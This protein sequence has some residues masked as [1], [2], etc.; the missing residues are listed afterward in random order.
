MARPRGMPRV[1]APCEEGA[2]GEC[3]RTYEVC[4]CR[5]CATMSAV[6]VHTDFELPPPATSSEHEEFSV[7]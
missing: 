7:E 2:H 1:C 3:L 5:V 4:G 6:V